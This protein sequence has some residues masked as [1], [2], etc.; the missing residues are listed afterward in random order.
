MFPDAVVKIFLTASLEERARRRG[1]EGCESVARR[2]HVDMSRAVS[3]LTQASDARIIDTTG[4]SIDDV[5]QE[6]LTCLANNSN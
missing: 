4:R 2:D 6:I 5:V 3:P 1:D